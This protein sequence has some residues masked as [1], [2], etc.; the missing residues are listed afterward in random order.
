MNADMLYVALTRARNKQQVN[1]C[2]IENYKPHT[3]Y[4][5]SYN[6]NGKYYVGSTTNLN[7]RKKNTK[8]VQNAAILNLEKQFKN[9]DL[10]TSYIN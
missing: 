5:Y 2:K 8:R 1:F 10:I 6:Y 3:G 7:K 9:M 4:I